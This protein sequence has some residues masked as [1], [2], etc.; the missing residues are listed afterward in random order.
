MTEPSV[1]ASFPTMMTVQASWTNSSGIHVSHSCGFAGP[2]LNTDAPMS[3]T[4]H[5]RNNGNKNFWDFILA[6]L[7]IMKNGLKRGAFPI[8]YPNSKLKVK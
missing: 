6:S 3:S 2:L 5:T 7:W 8:K 1:D 4:A